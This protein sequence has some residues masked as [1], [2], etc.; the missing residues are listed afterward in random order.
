MQPYRGQ[1]PFKLYV[2]TDRRWL[3]GRS[4]GEVLEEIV[5]AGATCIQL[6]E[7]DLD[8]EAFLRE[9][10]IARGVT[11]R[12]QIPLII[13]DNITVCEQSGADGV[14]LGQQD[15]SVREARARLGPGK[16]IGV[17]AKTTDLARK[18]Q[19]DGA[20][21]IGSGAI[22]GTQT[23]RDAAPLSRDVLREICATVT[24]PVVAIGGITAHNLSQLSHTGI[25]GVAVV[26]A[27]FAAPDLTAQT[28][29]LRQLVDGLEFAPA[30][31]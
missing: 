3:S 5:C 18:A 25:A 2:V 22:F 31:Q 30:V 19:C 4:L 21:Y 10:I 9:A 11:H 16:L 27:V 26:S 1:E 7:K 29:L 15:G 23:K 20:D 13:N 24:I 12:A 14:H 28:R 17:T 6:R 8:E